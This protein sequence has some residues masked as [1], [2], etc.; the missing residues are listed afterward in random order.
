MAVEIQFLG[1]SGTVTGSK[2]LVKAGKFRI[3]IDCGLFQGERTW[4][5]RNWEAPQFAINEIDAV[6]I[7]H[8]HIDHI[9][10]LPRFYAQGLKCPIFLTAPTAVLSQLLLIDSGRLQ[11]EGADYRRESHTSRH[12]IPMPLYTEKDARSVISYFKNVKFDISHEILPG[13][14]AEW[15]RMGHIAGAGSITLSI[16]GKTI[17]FSGDVGRYAVPILKDPQPVSYGDLL[18]IESTYG[19]RLHGNIDPKIKFAEIVKTTEKRNGVVIIPSF[20]VGRAQQL[21][22]YIR[23]LK[24]ERMIPD[25]PVI[26]DSPM[27]KEAT[28][29]YSRAIDEYDEQARKIYDQGKS[30]F[31]FDKLHFIKDREES[32]K[33]N[34]IDEPMIIIAA[35][36]MLSGGR[37]LHHLKHRISD[38]RNTVLFVGFQPPGSRGDWIKSGAQSLT[39][40]GR[41]VSINAEIE[42]ISMLSAHADKNELLKWCRSGN[43]TPGKVAVVHG[44]PQTARNF[45]ETLKQEMKWNSFVP[46]YLQ[47]ITV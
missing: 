41:E 47:K 37:I 21:L 35:S 10:M 29:V 24:Q 11:E 3:L 2:Y 22:Y 38:P 13:V 26:I 8:A 28:S 23:E 12:A 6:L 15:K 33:L 4:R 39:L 5:E 32:I 16:E 9:G 43:G 34:S 45:S 17:N 31:E 30:P 19:D 44:E 27:A 25:I 46:E 18:L 36:G 14:T 40:M 1:A 7:T 42:E 20:A